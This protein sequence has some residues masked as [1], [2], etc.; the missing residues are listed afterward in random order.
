MNAAEIL[1]K[2]VHS[3]F[4]VQKIYT[5]S[6]EAPSLRID[7]LMDGL[8]DGVLKVSFNFLYTFKYI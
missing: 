7:G 8:M 4:G 3:L 6:R 5:A 1:T 2:S